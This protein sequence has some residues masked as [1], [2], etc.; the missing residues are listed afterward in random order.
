MGGRVEV[1]CVEGAGV[2]GAEGGGGRFEMWG[3]VGVVVVAAVGG[4]GDGG[5]EIVVVAEGGAVGAPVGECA[6]LTGRACGRGG[7]GGCGGGGD[8]GGAWR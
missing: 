7:A 8:G 6:G 5:L 1:G 3:Y 4:R 2:G